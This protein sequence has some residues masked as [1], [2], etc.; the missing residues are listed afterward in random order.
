MFSIRLTV[1][2][3]IMHETP[4]EYCFQNLMCRIFYAITQIKIVLSI[5]S[6]AVIDL[7]FK[8]ES[9][10]H[11]MCLINH[12][13]RLITKIGASVRPFDCC[14]PVSVSKDIY[15][16]TRSIVQFSVIKSSRFC[17]EM[18]IN[19]F[20]MEITGFLIRAKLPLWGQQ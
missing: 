11:L 13:L 5:M 18:F 3:C 9:C 12:K 10:S 19:Q 8:Q 16:I 6:P 7:I 2:P 17:Y 1:I 4:I 14:A 20:G 15:N